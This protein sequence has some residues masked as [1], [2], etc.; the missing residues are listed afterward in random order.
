MFDLVSIQ[1]ALRAQHIDAWLL[2]D[3]RG[4]N[5][6]ARRILDMDGRGLSSRRFF[7]LIPA[8]GSP[9]KLVSRVEVFALDHLPGEKHVYLRGEELT[10][11]VAALLAGLGRVAMEY[12]PRNAVPTISRVDAGT[13]EL[14][15]SF[16]VDV[17]SSGDLVQLFEAAWD[18]EQ[19]AMHQESAR[20][21]TS[22]FQVAW[23]LIAEKTRDGGTTTEVEVRAAIMDHLH[24]RGLIAAHPAIVAVGPHGGDPHYEVDTQNVATIRAGDFV[25]VDLWGKL[26]RPRAVYSDYTRV[27]FVGDRVPDHYAQVFQ[28]VAQARD[29][30]IALIRTR[31]AEGVRLQGWEVDEA[32]RQVIVRAG[33]GDNFLHRTG[34]SIGEEI[35]GNGA[36][37]DNF[38]THEERLVLPRTGFSIE[39]GIYLPEFGIRS[40]VNVFIDG[41]GGVHVTGEPQTEVMPILRR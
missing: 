8:E 30:A 31:F 34:H 5:P 10:A 38:E 35:H 23:D 18:D 9:Q 13:M 32:A 36:N 12:S 6:L 24:S 15:K 37:M 17:V 26:E 20:A 16:G 2:Y 14:V 29:A 27:G 22:A 19:W 25:L 11:G 1:S 21:T 40:E 39:P 4:S 33:Y 28:V 41:D 7:Y 3:F